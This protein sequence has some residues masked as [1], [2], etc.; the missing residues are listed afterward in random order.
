MKNLI[1]K[2]T[3]ILLA[4]IISVSVLVV[5]LSA[6]AYS[7]PNDYIKEF[8]CPPLADKSKF[9][10]NDVFL[11]NY[12]L[13]FFNP[14]GN[15]YYFY[16]IDKKD[17]SKNFEFIDMASSYL[18]FYYNGSYISV[19]Y[20]FICFN[21][22][23]SLYSSVIS[24]GTSLSAGYSSLGVSLDDYSNYII[25]S[26]IPIKY[27][28]NTI[29]QPSMNREIKIKDFYT[30][31]V[32]SSSGS[33]SNNTLYG[34]YLD[35]NDETWEAFIQWLIDT[36]YYTELAQYGLRTSIS[37]LSSIAD[38][39][40]NN[41]FS[42][43]LVWELLK[44]NGLNSLDMA[45]GVI[46]WF[47][48]K[49]QLYISHNSVQTIWDTENNKNYHHRAEL[50]EDFTDEDGNITD[51]TDTSILR[52]I[53]RQIINL[54]SNFYNL[55]GG[56]INNIASNVYALC[57][58]AYDMPEN[59]ASS[60]QTHFENTFAVV[61]EAEANIVDTLLKLNIGDS[62][63]SYNEQNLFDELEYL[64]I[65]QP[66]PDE[67]KISTIVGN[68]FA[69][70][71]QIRD[72]NALTYDI[73]M[74]NKALINTNDNLYSVL[75]DNYSDSS[76]VPVVASS[77]DVVSSELTAPDL[78]VNLSCFGAET[79]VSVFNFSVFDNYKSLV[80]VFIIALCWGAYLRHLFHRLPYFLRF[81]VY[82]GSSGEGVA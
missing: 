73:D 71:K 43:A 46:S 52:E 35:R 50:I 26:D 25:Y 69:F 81:G 76:L 21:S 70:V 74:S 41:K 72:L 6:S 1:I 56:T 48:Q 24:N 61:G 65:P 14:K 82:S 10:N 77:S 42:P 45:K 66:I 32:V 36:G 29:Y 2:F 16:F 20:G 58:Y 64:F 44:N 28:N 62:E 12:S 34:M 13:V 60:F 68:K 23:G 8:D 4:V 31:N 9:F 39:W 75:C 79:S 49:W 38:V 53:L 27:N 33:D 7:Y 67:Y 18:K 80:H 55:F 37:N 17:N 40:W 3:S 51:S 47:N 57:Q 59:I 54:P 11:Y 5:P 63:C 22:D 78:S 15:K 30:W 19:D